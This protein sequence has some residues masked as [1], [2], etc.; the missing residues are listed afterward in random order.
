MKRSLKESIFL[1]FKGMAMGAADVVPGVSGGTIAFISG[2]YEELLESIS[3]INLK[4]IADLKEGGIKKVWK[5]INGD[6]LLVL[7]CGI[8]V[9]VLSLAKGISYLLKNEPILLW[10][11]FFG[12]VLASV[13]F[14]GKQINRWTLTT[15]VLLF[16]GAL[17]AYYITIIEP[18]VSDEP[19]M[20]FLFLS[21]ALAICAMILPG[22]S[23]SFILVLL[24]AYSSIL[25]A[26]YTR[27]L[28]VIATVG[29]GAI[30]GLLSFSKILKW[31]FS[32]YKNLTLAGL[33]GFIIG[34]LNKIW[35]W[36]ETLT[37][38]ENSHGEQVPLL[39]KS[40]SPL[41]FEGDHQLAYAILVSCIGYAVIV[42][43]EK[44]QNAKISS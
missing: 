12:L 22:I 29:V 24:G 40:I 35:P 4:L 41:S 1:F 27:N 6:F 26:I 34:S 25:E 15:Y 20:F 8:A 23:G 33:T 19:S 39:Q 5:A 7:L 14:V 17:A 43:L 28:Q 3:A 32:H 2:I 31:L 16:L 18:L 37:W 10:S 42:G 11:F 13:V 38:R 21:G 9:S 30:V 36:K 44:I